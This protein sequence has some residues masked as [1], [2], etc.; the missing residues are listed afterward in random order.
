MF[1][2]TELG[3]AVEVD[4]RTGFVLEGGVM[5]ARI[6]MLLWLFKMIDRE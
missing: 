5:S 2:L 1:R 4:R 6:Q 3:F